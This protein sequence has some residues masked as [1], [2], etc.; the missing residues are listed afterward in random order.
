MRKVKKIINDPEDIVAE[1]LEGAVL[2]SHGLI[3]RLEG[4]PA[5]IRS[6]IEEGMGDIPARA[7]SL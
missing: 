3:E 5:L 1:V 4:V 7:G 6:K 2:A